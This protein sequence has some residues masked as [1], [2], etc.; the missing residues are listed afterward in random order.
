MWLMPSDF[1]LFFD[2]DLRVWCHVVSTFL[3]SQEVQGPSREV[4]QLHFIAVLVTPI[5][6][7]NRSMPWLVYSRS[8]CVIVALS[9]LCIWSFATQGSPP[10]AEQRRKGGKAS[11]DNSNERFDTRPY[12]YRSNGPRWVLGVGILVQK[13]DTNNSGD[14]DTSIL[15]LAF[16]QFTVNLYRDSLTSHRV[17]ECL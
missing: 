15:R 16:G 4:H 2:L 13:N 3:P 1:N 14:A 8:A 6:L 7:V 12:K 9:L 17:E 10:A 5:I 11:A